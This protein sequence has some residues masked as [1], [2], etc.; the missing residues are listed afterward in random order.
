MTRRIDTRALSGAV[1]AAFCAFSA[2][3]GGDGAFLTLFCLSAFAVPAVSFFRG[4]PRPR[5]SSAPFPLFAYLGLGFLWAS[6]RGAG[7][8]ALVE[9]VLLAGLGFLAVGGGVFDAVFLSIC[10]MGLL[11][12]AAN[13]GLDSP[14]PFL[15]AF[16]AMAWWLSSGGK[17]RKK[18]VPPIRRRGS[19][20]SAAWQTGAFALS[21]GVV[22]LFQPRLASRI[23]FSSAPSGGSEAG[24]FPIQ[25]FFET[26]W[27]AVRGSASAFW[28]FLASPW[29]AAFLLSAFSAAVL[30]IFRGAIAA[31]SA[32][33]SARRRGE[34]CLRSA[35]KASSRNDYGECVRLCYMATRAFLE[36]AGHPKK[37]GADLFDY[38]ADLEG[39]PPEARKDAL[40]V[41][42]LYSKL[43]YGS[44][45][46]ARRDSDEAL[47]R[48][49]EIARSPRH[50]R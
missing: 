21:A 2:E 30:Y 24:G 50:P 22:W 7:D 17:W 37:E 39:I 13:G 27:L 43:V 3:G 32:E 5:T 25:R 9:A 12:G 46:A 14:Y 38:A 15:A 20:F 35:G 4:V 23:V 16:A 11:V 48:A 28:D 40:V 19:A 45:G 10:S 34:R 8:A 49:G 1:L 42:L 26:L 47:R 29:G 36:A 6:F 44:L 33:I 41:F 18:L 31:F